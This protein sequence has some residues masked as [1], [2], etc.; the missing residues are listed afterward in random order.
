MTAR[1]IAG[2]SLALLGATALIAQSAQAA[3][4]ADAESAYYPIVKIP[5]PE[6]IV[7]EA[8]AIQRFGNDRIAV[9]TRLGDIYFID[10]AF[11]N[12]PHHVKFTKFASGL[13][14]VL[15]LTTKG[16]GWWYAT[17]RGEITRIRDT[18]GD[19]RADVFET[20]CD[21]WEIG[22]DY[23]EYAFG[24]KFDQN[25]D[26][27]VTL[28][29]TGS[30]TSENLYRGWCLRVKPDG[31]AVPTCSGVR[32]PGGIATNHLGDMFY[33]D[34]QGPWNGTCWLKHLKPGGFMGNPSGWK[35][36]ANATNM[37][38][39]PKMPVSNSRIATEWKKIPEFVPP[40]V[41]FPYGKMG[42]SASGIQNDFTAGKFGPYANQLFVGDQTWST[43]MRVY[44][45][46]VEGTYQGACFPFREGFGSGSLG[47]E[48]CPDGSLFVY[49]TDRGWGARGGKPFAL[50]R[51][52]WNG[53]TPFEIQE[54]H[55]KP[56]G[57]ELTFT[58][59]VDPAAAAKLDSYEIATFTYLYRSDYGS[60]EVD[61]T[62]PELKAAKVSP[63][64][65]S[66]RLIFNPVE[67]HIHEFKLKGVTDQG[68]HSLLHSSAWY[69]LNVIPKS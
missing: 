51:L 47:L 11:E 64:G 62:K 22:G 4:V 41:G 29:L 69:T 23:H 58:E 49:G 6:G 30:F 7:L 42:Q 39:Q 33:T 36:Y 17:Q 1:R 63:D 26:I 18:N 10:G 54:I 20:Y 50:E 45:E 34:N 13:H 19:D 59:P 24:S 60:P 66:V 3:S 32:S 38:P 9:S 5:I 31:T 8:G 27:W 68:G 56:D 28:C 67:G 21:T 12:P 14:E 25:G 55:A 35:W 15:G 61:S 37:G 52:V 46:K 44:L 53:K 40:A 16:D 43:V 57:F 48:M 65:K 2:R